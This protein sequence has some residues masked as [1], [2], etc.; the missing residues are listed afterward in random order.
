[1]NRREDEKVSS[2]IEW[3][4][5]VGKFLRKQYVGRLGILKGDSIV[6]RENALRVT[7]EDANVEKIGIS[8]G[9]IN[10]KY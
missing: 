5:C 1:M 2:Y 10:A 9:D 3:E 6:G 8:L 4:N 7:R